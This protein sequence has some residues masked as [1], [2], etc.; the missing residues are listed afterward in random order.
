MPC[1]RCAAVARRLR[2]DAR[3]CAGIDLRVGAGEIVA[4]LGSNGAGKTTLN[5]VAVRRPA[6]RAGRDPLRRR[7]TRPRRSSP[8]IVEAGPR[9][10]CR[11]AADLPEP[12]A[13][14]RTSSSALSRADATGAPQSRARL[15]R[16]SRACASARR[17][18]PARSSGGEQQMLAIGRGLMAEPRLLIL[19]EPSLGLSPLLVEEM[20][21]LIRASTPTG[22]RSCWSSRTWCSRWSSHTRLRAG[23][24]RLRPVGFGGTGPQRPRT[25]ARLSGN[26]TEKTHDDRH[27]ERYSRI[28]PVAGRTAALARAVGPVRGRRWFADLPARRRR[29]HQAR[30]PRLHRRHCSR[31]AGARDA[32]PRCAPR[33]ARGRRWSGSG[34]RGSAAA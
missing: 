19:D 22:C 12:D 18:A 15:R 29:A 4:V 26:V 13:C 30:A 21:A 9:S 11:R 20:F 16:S 34:D 5:K 24:R 2:R 14:A 23:E 28:R 8:A 10:R 25:E 32:Q 3:C 6:R 7:D 1:L 31:N 33:E 27:A 17:S